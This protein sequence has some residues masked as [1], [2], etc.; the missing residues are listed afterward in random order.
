MHIARDI[1][2]AEDKDR[3]GLVWIIRRI[4]Q[5]GYIRESKSVFFITLSYIVEWA[6]KAVDPIGFRSAL[7]MRGLSGHGVPN[8][9]G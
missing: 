8:L 9:R 3:T 4:W 2:D 5:A 1:N 6:G 7:E